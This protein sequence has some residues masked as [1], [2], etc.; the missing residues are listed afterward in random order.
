MYR[1]SRLTVGLYN[2]M[3]TCCAQRATVL[4]NCNIT[5]ITD[6]DDITWDLTGPL[7]STYTLY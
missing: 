6:Y 5:L 4:T 1:N 7:S 3:L 2:T